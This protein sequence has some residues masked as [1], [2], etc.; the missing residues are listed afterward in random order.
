MAND[1]GDS[2]A[3]SRDR[4]REPDDP[5]AGAKV[6]AAVASQ[7]YPAELAQRERD[8]VEKRRELLEQDRSS[9]VIGLALSGGGIRSATFSLG[10][11][12][13]LSSKRLLRRIDYLS[14]VSGGGYIGSFLGGLFVARP[15][16][17]AKPREA[18]NHVDA[19][20]DNGD[21]GPVRWLRENG[22][23]MAPTG[24]G[25]YLFAA[26]IYLRNWV[27]IHYVI[28][29][30]LLALFLG[31]D[32]LRAGMWNSTR[33]RE[34]ECWFG[35]PQ[36][37]GLWWSVWWLLPALT[38]LL[39]IIPLGW[40][41]WLVQGERQISRTTLFTTGLVVLIAIGV[42]MLSED[43]T[44]KWSAACVIVA[45]ILAAGVALSQVLATE[46]MAV[47]RNR[48]STWLSVAF[49][50]FL[51]LSGFALVDSFAQSLYRLFVSADGWSMTAIVGTAL[52]PAIAALVRALAPLFGAGK[53]G[54]L[55]DWLPGD[56][57]LT[58]AGIFLAL[59]VLVFW[60]TVGHAIFHAFQAPAVPH[61]TSASGL[62]IVAGAFA[63]CALISVLNAQTMPFLNLSSLQQFYAARLTRAYLGAS[64]PARTG[65]APGLELKTAPALDAQD[66][67]TAHAHDD[68]PWPQYHP[69][70]NGGPVHLVNVTL[71][72]TVSGRSQLEQRDRKG[73]GMTLGP[74]GASVGRV[75]HAVWDADKP[76]SLVPVAP[77]RGQYRVF[78]SEPGRAVA[79]EPLRLGQW[80]AVSGAAFTTGLGA[81]T[82][83]GKS[84]L[85]GLSNVRLGYW[86]DSTINPQLR[87]GAIP[88]GIVAGIGRL[89]FRAFPA[90]S[91][92][93]SELLARF[94]GP[95]RIRWYLSDGGHFENTGVYE[96]LR[97]RVGLIIACD[98]GHD[99]E[100]ILD[101]LANLVRKARIDLGAEVRFLTEPELDA[102][103]GNDS[104]ARRV[105]GTPFQ[106]QR[107]AASGAS[108]R[109]QGAAYSQRHA[110]LARVSYGDPASPGSTLLL[111]KPT[112][113]GD[114]PIDLHEYHAARPSFPQESTLDQ[115]FDEAQWESYRRLGAHIGDSLF[116]AVPAV[117]K[118]APALMR[119]LP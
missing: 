5:S 17:P 65:G 16:S 76:E 116:S 110:A 38:L 22:R 94:H 78:E 32:L 87:Q 69:E 64:N 10:I 7:L 53:G 28:A 72:E 75:H 29:V 68:I 85:L 33:W 117:D 45:G 41:Y 30:A 70:R 39:A 9:P 43:S 119:P 90:Q 4:D 88:H 74:C 96:L 82:S 107:S 18:A 77:P 63:L 27:S 52:P 34:L 98:N 66:V 95:N 81:G 62:R 54:R 73:L 108:G 89:L 99:P 84:L 12:Q 47:V 93:L 8:A 51:A 102:A 13:A 104:P 49:G 19:V 101:D 111:I 40:A 24:S 50:L 79:V 92:L 59:L 97:R 67:T 113:I 105:I 57:L 60:A 58:A 42:A 56:V 46:G 100:Y 37:A 118:W 25:D 112:L 3:A 26:A 1:P 35:G 48:L 109:F 55:P 15:A 14:T 31:A 114:E 36:G 20:L 71:N 80:I 11:L 106:L 103:L 83:L 23:Y 2:T 115:F 6:S 91:Y 44:V 86:W 21:S 61:P